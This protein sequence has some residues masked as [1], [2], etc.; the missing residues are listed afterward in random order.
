MRKYPKNC[1]KSEKISNL[2]FASLVI[3]YILVSKKVVEYR[4]HKFIWTIVDVLLIFLFLVLL[5]IL[6]KWVEILL[7][8]VLIF[9]VVQYYID[10]IISVFSILL[11]ILSL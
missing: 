6:S 3:Y 7:V 4:I 1:R 5:F 8:L 9:V 2:F 11:T 10:I